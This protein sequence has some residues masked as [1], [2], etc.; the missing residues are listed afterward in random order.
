MVI[1]V[2]VDPHH[3]EAAKQLGCDAVLM[4][5]MPSSDAPYAGD[6]ELIR[7]I[8]E[9]TDGLGVDVVL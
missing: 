2:E 8:E 5:N 1:G 7:Q 9:L 6:P 4:P 3:A